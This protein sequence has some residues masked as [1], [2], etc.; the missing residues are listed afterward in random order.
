MNYSNGC[1][2]KQQNSP[3]IKFV[4]KGVATGIATTMLVAP[5]QAQ[6]SSSFSSLLEEVVVTAR[7]REEGLQDTPIAV[8]AFTGDSLQARGIEKVDGIESVTPNLTFA[9]RNTNGGGSNSAS[10]FI[11]GVGQA[12]NAPTT[13]AGV[14]LYVDGVYLAR[15]TGSVLDLIDIERIEVLRGPQGTLFGRNTIGGAVS[16]HTKK[17]TEEFEGKVRVKVGSDSRRDFLGKISGPLTENLFA[18]ASVASLR[19]DGYVKNII[20][21]QDLGDDDT[22][23][24]RGAL[25]WLAS[26]DLEINVAADYSRD[27][28]NGQVRIADSDPQDAITII[29]PDPTNPRSL[30]NAVFAH[31]V[32]FGLNSPLPAIPPGRAT[33][34]DATFANPLGTNSNCMRLDTINPGKLST[35]E[36][37]FS[38]AEIYGLS[39]SID[40]SLSD[41]LTLKSI[42]AYREIDSHFFQDGDTSPFDNSTVE[43]FLEQEQVSQEFQLL[44]SSFDDTVQWILGLYYFNEEGVND[45]PV[46]FVTFRALS[47]GGFENESKAAFA[48]ATWDVT[49]QLHLTAGLRYTKD[50]KEFSVNGPQQNLYPF[51]APPGTVVTIIPDGTYKTDA[52]DWTPMFN[53]SYDWS[54]N[55]MV[56]ATYSEGFKSGGVQQRLAGAFPAAPT[57]DP[58]FVTSRELGLKY[59]SDDGALVINAAI[60][61]SDYEDIQLEVQ[62]GIA[63]VLDNGGEGEI[64]GA[65]LEVRYSPA[66]SWFIESAV[67]YL[68]ATIVEADPAATAVGGPADGDWLSSVPRWT[69]SASLIK[70]IDL[71]DMGVLR[72]R[73]DW[74]FRGNVFFN[75]N[76]DPGHVQKAYSIYNANIAWDSADDKYSL[77]LSVNNIDDERYVYYN[78]ASPASGIGYEILGRGREWYLTGEVRF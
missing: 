11:R 3:L 34:C 6:T 64:K 61:D 56:Y 40:W 44:G 33:G 41:T 36:K 57:Y 45:N 43:D 76:N 72:P 78:E 15:S 71:G 28:E 35:N 54:D 20:N 18:S 4:A 39:A 69:A 47:G 74:S 77:T 70:E 66:E 12:D 63:P 65:E 73:L 13:D 24:F 60:F 22:L 26:D 58:E 31:N 9:N 75:P 19:Q 68:D 38:N 37:S 1:A 14:G 52:D 55:V 59:N 8:S 67:G 62:S 32:F 48:Q 30:G 50:E 16:I 2:G 51:L 49:E 25:R 21:G 7:K 17:P 46:K 23:A 42:T 29:P 53:L 10:I 27:R 5:A